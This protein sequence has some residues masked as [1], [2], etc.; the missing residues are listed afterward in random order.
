M[1]RPWLAA[2]L[3]AACATSAQAGEDLKAIPAQ[4]DPASAYLLIDIVSDPVEDRDAPVL[5]ARYDRVH[6][7]ISGLGRA[8]AAPVAKSE[9]Q[10]VASKVGRSL[11][12]KG[13]R[14]APAALDGHG[15]G[16]IAK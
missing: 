12:P 6:E 1:R 9:D 16:A 5:F 11:R 14:P 4:L 8:S 3:L 7:D 10:R 15:D 13:W 2:P